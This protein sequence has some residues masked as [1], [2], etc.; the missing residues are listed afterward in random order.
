M[1]AQADP[2]AVRV[3]N[4]ERVLGASIDRNPGL[5]ETR[6]PGGEVID[7]E[8]EDV[9]RAAR[10]PIAEKPQLEHQ[11]GL[12]G[13]EPERARPRAF[14]VPP[15]DRQ[16]EEA[17]VER[18]RALEVGHAQREVMDAHAYLREA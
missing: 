14:E 7:G 2:V 12:A 8:R 15:Q 10:R 9:T 18:R 16:A 13:A 5:V 1:V 11:H 6:L 17:G 4:V 3:A